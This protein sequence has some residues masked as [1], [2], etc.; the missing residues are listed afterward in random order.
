MEAPGPG[1][2]GHKQGAAGS[3]ETEL[4]RSVEVGMCWGDSYGREEV[5]R[6]ANLA[7][8]VLECQAAL[9]GA[10][11][12]SQGKRGQGQVVSRGRHRETEGQV[13]GWEWGPGGDRSHD[14]D[15]RN[16]DRS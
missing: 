3:L 4:L 10:G 8:M 2:D 16:G 11:P 14:P 12:F 9:K 7:M 15:G 5:E 1:R 6:R 13:W